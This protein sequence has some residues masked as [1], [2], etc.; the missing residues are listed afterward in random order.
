MANFGS[1]LMVNAEVVSLCPPFVPVVSL[2][3]MNSQNGSDTRC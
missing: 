3:A 1:E 2:A